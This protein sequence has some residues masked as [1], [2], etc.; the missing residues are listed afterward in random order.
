MNQRGASSG[1]K[2]GLGLT[3]RAEKKEE[4]EEVEEEGVMESHCPG[5]R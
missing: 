2:G 1:N 5:L 4:E 3:G